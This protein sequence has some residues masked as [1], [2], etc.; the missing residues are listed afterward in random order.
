MHDRNHLSS[1]DELRN[2]AIQEH[3]EPL[4]GSSG[5]SWELL[6]NEC[7][8][9]GT[10]RR[11]YVTKHGLF[12]A[13]VPD[14]PD[15]H[16]ALALLSHSTS[17]QSAFGSFLCRVLAQERSR[18]GSCPMST[19]LPGSF[20]ALSFLRHCVRHDRTI[21]AENFQ[22]P[23]PPKRT[24]SKAKDHKHMEAEIALLEEAR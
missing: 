22:V 10:S 18:T 7:L 2:S 17:C 5:F 8:L 11:V 13:T 19:W 6:L 9:W 23:R 1:W 21:W 14:G 3:A 24:P 4:T 12:C 15:K 20:S 16:Q